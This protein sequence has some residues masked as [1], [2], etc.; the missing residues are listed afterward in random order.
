MADRVRYNSRP[1]TALPLCEVPFLRFPV[2]P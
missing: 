1:C 2:D